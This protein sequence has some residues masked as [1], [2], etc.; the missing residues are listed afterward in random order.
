M[1]ILLKS[2]YWFFPSGCQRRSLCDL[3]LDPDLIGLYRL[4][5]IYE[6]LWL[7]L[8]FSGSH[9]SVESLKREHSKQEDV[10]GF[11]FWR[12]HWRRSKGCRVRLVLLVLYL[13]SLQPWLN[14]EP[15]GSPKVRWQ[16][17]YRAVDVSHDIMSWICLKELKP[18][19]CQYNFSTTV[20]LL[21]HSK[22]CT[23]FTLA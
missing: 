18:G 6:R 17:K 11:L 15:A 5:K 22:C 13:I 19:S 12:F 1:Y 16:M 2:Q 8:G 7:N 21:E 9:K 23:E 3:L 20:L 4:K 14:L 10:P